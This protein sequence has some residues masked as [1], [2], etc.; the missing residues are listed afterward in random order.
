MFGEGCTNLEA[1]W[2]LSFI[3]NTWNNKGV[4]F[5]SCILPSRGG[6][7]DS[8]QGRREPQSRY[9]PPDLACSRE[10]LWASHCWPP[11]YGL[12]PIEAKR[13]EPYRQIPSDSLSKISTRSQYLLSSWPG[14]LFNQE[15][16]EGA[17]CP[18]YTEECS[19]NSKLFHSAAFLK[20]RLLVVGKR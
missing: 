18:R 3:S 14:V 10:F 6:C 19:L 5:Q 16:V 17:L 2:K 9:S 11:E 1:I 15:K 8:A 13:S 7:A 4:I 12:L 20:L